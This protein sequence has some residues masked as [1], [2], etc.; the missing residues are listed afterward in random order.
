MWRRASVALVP[1]RD[2]VGQDAE[3]ALE[4]DAVFLAQERHVCVGSDELVRHALVHQRHGGFD[5]RLVEGFRH[6]V[7]VHRE[8][9]TV[10][11]LPRARQRRHEGP[12]GECFP[13]TRFT[14]IQALR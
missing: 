13:D 1:Y 11:P 3:L 12:V 5:R 10:E 9:G 4:I 6:Q 2:R 7:A 8:C 14:C